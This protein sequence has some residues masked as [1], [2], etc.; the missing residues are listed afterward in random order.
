MVEIDVRGRAKHSVRG[1]W[2]HLLA[3]LIRCA[4]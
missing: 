4:T 2:V 1:V 3:L